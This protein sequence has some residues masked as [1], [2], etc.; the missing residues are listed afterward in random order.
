MRFIIFIFFI[1]FITYQ[2]KADFL[3][4]WGG[5]RELDNLEKLFKAFPLGKIVNCGTAYISLNVKKIKGKNN[6]LPFNKKMVGVFQV[7]IEG[8]Y[9]TA[10]FVHKGRVGG[11]TAY[12]EFF[13]LN[14]KV[15]LWGKGHRDQFHSV[16]AI[17]EKYWKFNYLLK[18]PKILDK[19]NR[20]TLFEFQGKIDTK[21]GTVLIRRPLDHS[22]DFRGNDFYATTL[23]LGNCLVSDRVGEWKWS[24]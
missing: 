12:P 7:F 6:Y 19:F 8:D 2:V 13:D 15:V 18:G 17:R 22:K 20:N 9:V 11:Q 3:P 23:E 24:K 4:G 5:E 14:Q 1:S 16:F 10:K 21:G